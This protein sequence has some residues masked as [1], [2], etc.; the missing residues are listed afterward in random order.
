MIELKRRVGE[1]SGRGHMGG[2]RSENNRVDRAALRCRSD[3]G[4]KCW[5]KGNF[6]GPVIT[7]R[8]Y[9]QTG[10]KEL[11]GSNKKG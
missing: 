1:I 4:R 8:L 3:S 2:Q 11:G 6:G 10:D 9:I 5:T 7:E